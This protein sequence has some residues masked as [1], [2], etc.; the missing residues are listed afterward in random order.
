MP[1]QARNAPGGFVYHAL[2]RAVARLPL[3]QKDGDYAAF[4]RLLAEALQEDP[5]RLLSYCLMPN[6]WHMVLWPREDDELTSFLRW[7]SHTHSMRWHAHY[8]TGGTGHIYQGRF[9]SFPVESDDH[10]LT[11]LRYVERNALRANLVARAEDWRWTSLW[12]RQRASENVEP[13]IALETWPVAMPANWL[14]FVNSAHTD[15]ELEALRRAVARSSPFGT[16]AWCAS[17]AQR[18]GLQPSLRPLG[19]PRKQA[20]EDSGSLF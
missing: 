2:N 20:A 5:T 4:E 6:H 3:F 8:H 12:R 18:L 19:R 10:L 1:R 11:V 13:R 14:E 7:L 16:A 15:G 17:T 9:K